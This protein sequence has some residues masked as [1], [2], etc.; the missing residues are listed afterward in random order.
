VNDHNVTEETE[1][2]EEE[3]AAVEVEVEAEADELA[4][5]ISKDPVF[6]TGIVM[7]EEREAGQIQQ[8]RQGQVQHDDC[9][10]PPRPHLENV[11]G[12]GHCVPRE[13][14]EEDDAI[15]DGKVLHLE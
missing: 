2:G 9:T 5:E 4:H 6:T 15:D 13:A 7:D 12:D 11:D 14:H 10:A 8:V 1:A 3:N